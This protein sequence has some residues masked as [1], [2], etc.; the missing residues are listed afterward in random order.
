[1]NKHFLVFFVLILFSGCQASITSPETNAAAESLSPSSSIL[2]AISPVSMESTMPNEFYEVVSVTDGDTIKVKMNG[3]T[4]TLRLLGMDTPE[5]VDPRTEV[6]CFGK[7]ASDKA[8]E[9]LTGKKVRLESDPTQGELDKYQRLLRY[10]YLE[11]GT[12]F[13]K[14][15]IENGFAHEYT[16]NAPH[17]YQAE[18]KVAEKTAREN[19]R[20]FWGDICNGDTTKPAE[21]PV[22]RATVVPVV[23]VA[24]RGNTGDYICNCAK[25]C[26]QMSCAEAQFQ[27]NECG[28]SRRDGDKDGVACDSQC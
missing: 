4:E 25:T 28:C 11:D 21:K 2:P 20:G 9:L 15:M 5:T 26:T 6:Q 8:K 18:F 23:P 1:M 13:N 19:K 12:S 10:V 17:K 22:A 27:L 16:Y 3:K 24:P 7:E 14:W